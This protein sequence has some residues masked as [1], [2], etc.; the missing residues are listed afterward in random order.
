MA[1]TRNRSIWI[2]FRH[3]NEFSNATPQNAGRLC[4]RSATLTTSLNAANPRRCASMPC[5]VWGPKKGPRRSCL[6]AVSKFQGLQYETHLP[7]MVP[8][9]PA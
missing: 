8:P 1:G 5:D 7:K 4:T 3:G 2:L 9:H 6:A